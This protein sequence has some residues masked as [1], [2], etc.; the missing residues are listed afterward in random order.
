[1][2][3]SAYLEAS[4]TLGRPDTREAA[5]KALDFLWREMRAPEGG[6][7]RFLPAT[8]AQVPSP[9]PQIAGIFAD[10]AYT[11][12]A[13]LDAAEVTGDSVY[14]DRALELSAFILDRFVHR[15]VDGEVAGFYDVWDATPE[16]GRLRDRQKSMQ[17]NAVCAE[18]FIRLHHLTREERYADAAKGTLEAFA[19]AYE[20]MGHFAAAYARPSTC[21]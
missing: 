18:V 10:Q 14:L 15:D 19:G 4:W 2:A 8:V 16:V 5:L 7:Y 11:A 12:R 1:M 3:I 20:Q 6:V 9:E 21:C 13:L 17:D